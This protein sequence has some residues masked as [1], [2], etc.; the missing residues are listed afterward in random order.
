MYLKISYGKW[1]P[2]CLCFNV[3]MTWSSTWYAICVIWCMW[4][5]GHSW[6]S[7]VVASGLND[8]YIGRSTPV[9]LHVW[10]L[11]TDRLIGVGQ[12]Q[13]DV[14]R[15][16]E[17]HELSRLTH[18]STYHVPIAS[19][20]VNTAR[21]RRLCNLCGALCWTVCNASVWSI[22]VSNY[23]WGQPGWVPYTAK[24]GEDLTGKQSVRISVTKW[25]T[26]GYVFK[27]WCN[28]SPSKRIDFWC[29][30]TPKFCHT[31]TNTPI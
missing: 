18:D 23:K 20:T 3:L 11:I 24:R 26:V 8:A 12:P 29:K 30:L 17:R 2:F 21:N 15:Y 22:S 13:A 16:G 7:I 19:E 6:I 9:V 1:P 31:R 25:C 5:S 14:V 10:V 28:R 27:A 4:H